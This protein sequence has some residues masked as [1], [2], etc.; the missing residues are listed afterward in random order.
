MDE[1]LVDRRDSGIAIVRLNRPEARNALN[2]EV[3]QQLATHLAALGQDSEVRCIVLTG[4]DRYFAAGSDLRDCCSQAVTRRRACRPSSRNV[5]P[6][7]QE[8]ESCSIA[9]QRIATPEDIDC[10]VTLGL[11]YPRGPLAMGDALGAGTVL[12]IL[13]RLYDFYRD[14][15]YRPSP[16]LIRRARLGV[17][18]LTPEN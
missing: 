15:R 12:T 17:S 14:P 11:G 16:W 7:L 10:A 3:R 18:L 9:Q 1:V 8:P 13:A 4:G 5:N 6:A 2:Q